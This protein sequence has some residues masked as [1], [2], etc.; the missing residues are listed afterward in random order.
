MNYH[1]T[2]V[3][4]KQCQ[5]EKLTAEQISSPSFATTVRVLPAIT[6]TGV[7]SDRWLNQVKQEQKK[8][9]QEKDQP[10]SF[11]GKYWMYIAVG[12]FVMMSAGG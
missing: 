5:P 9:A 7:D 4:A 1:P 10:Q 6:S 11:F 3:T 12:L 2:K 8:K